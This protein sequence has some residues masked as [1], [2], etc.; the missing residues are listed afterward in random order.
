MAQ[1]WQPLFRLLPLGRNR[2]EDFK[3]AR[4]VGCKPLRQTLRNGSK[5]CT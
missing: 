1:H 3:E 2:V 5:D 4:I